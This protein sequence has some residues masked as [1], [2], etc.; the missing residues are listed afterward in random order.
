MKRKILILV[1]FMLFLMTNTVCADDFID[2]S[3]VGYKIDENTGYWGP[4]DNIVYLTDQSIEPYTGGS[5][6]L[7][8]F[9]NYTL[10]IS[11]GGGA[12]KYIVNLYV[13]DTA[14]YSVREK[15]T[16]VIP[17]QSG[18]KCS[19][20]YGNAVL[21]NYNIDSITDTVYRLLGGRIVS[22]D[23]TEDGGSA[24]LTVELIPET[25][26][27]ITARYD[28]ASR[29][30]SVSAMCPKWSG[31]GVNVSVTSKDGNLLYVNQ[32]TAENG[33]IGCEF[34]LDDNAYDCKV[35]VSDSDGSYECDGIVFYASQETADASL[36]LDTDGQ[37]VK[38]TVKANNAFYGTN[39]TDYVVVAFYGSN[40]ALIDAEIAKCRQSSVTLGVRDGSAKVKAFLMNSLDSITPLTVSVELP[41]S[42]Q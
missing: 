4:P 21:A 27:R 5:Y 37:N 41:L 20:K 22:L 36:A 26:P 31:N 35:I 16:A 18:W 34:E 24:T 33:V 17:V 15:K 40:G 39:A 30:M 3:K 9:A 12:V 10:S 6:E 38:V 14:D 29:Y 1:A 11:D 32:V 28:T 23:V 19:L 25:Q 7:E 13:T 42:Q 2:W 8:R